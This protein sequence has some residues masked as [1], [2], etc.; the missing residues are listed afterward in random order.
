MF[1]YV[2][3]LFYINIIVSFV[4]LPHCHL[5]NDLEN[6]L[7]KCE[8]PYCAKSSWHSD[9]LPS[10]RTAGEVCDMDRCVIVL[11]DRTTKLM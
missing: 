6:D 1:R 3:L 2:Y 7:W 10:L 5:E 9:S 8:T 4:N 11:F